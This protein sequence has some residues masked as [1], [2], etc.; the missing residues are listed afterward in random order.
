MG[1]Q[2]PSPPRRRPRRQSPQ[3]A[4]N[5]VLSPP[6]SRVL[7]PVSSRQPSRVLSPVSS[8]QPSRPRPPSRRPPKPRAQ[9]LALW[10]LAQLRQRGRRRSPVVSLTPSRRPRWSDF[11]LSSCAMTAKTMASR[12]RL[13]RL[14]TRAGSHSRSPSRPRTGST[15]PTMFSV[16][17]TPTRITLM[18]VWVKTTFLTTSRSCAEQSFRAR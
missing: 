6:P 12:G 3:T 17:C 7:S 5:R 13:P 4:L 16:T 2:R 9:P 8:R 11:R 18:S 10:K 14:T 15:F 1:S